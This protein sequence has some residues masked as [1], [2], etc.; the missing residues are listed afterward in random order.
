M[1]IDFRER[2]EEREKEK[3]LCEKEHQSVAFLTCT[4]KESNS[5]PFSILDN[6]PTN[7]QGPVYILFICNNG[8]MIFRETWVEK[9]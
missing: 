8:R 3:D 6:T 5:Q 4:D 1:L 9:I 2:A 7:Y